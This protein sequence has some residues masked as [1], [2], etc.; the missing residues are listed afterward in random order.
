MRLLGLL[1]RSWPGGRTAFLPFRDAAARLYQETRA[2][3]QM[4]DSRTPLSSAAC[5]DYHRRQLIHYAKYRRATIYGRRVP[6]TAIEP[7]AESDLWTGNCT[8]DMSSWITKHG[9]EY[10]DLSIRHHDLARVIQLVKRSVKSHG[11]LLAWC[12]YHS[13]GISRQSL[14]END[15]EPTSAKAAENVA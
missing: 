7:I 15:G 13:A 12:R 10:A 1:Y 5:L 4:A 9:V 14:N 6:G 11:A 2:A 8:E 3:E